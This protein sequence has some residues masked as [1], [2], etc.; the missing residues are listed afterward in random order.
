[1]RTRG[2]G[3]LVYRVLSLAGNNPP[4]NKDERLILLRKEVFVEKPDR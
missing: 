2:F 4:G 3:L 1:M